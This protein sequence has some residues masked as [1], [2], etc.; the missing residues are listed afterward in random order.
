MTNFFQLR[1]EEGEKEFGSRSIGDIFYFSS[2][3]F[4]DRGHDLRLL[5]LNI[6]GFIIFLYKFFQYSHFSGA[7]QSTGEREN[8]SKTI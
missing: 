4:G 3:I 7:P 2:C 6:E 8:D 5:P 1:C